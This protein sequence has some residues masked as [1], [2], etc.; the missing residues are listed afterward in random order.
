M[1]LSVSL[2]PSIDGITPDGVFSFTLYYNNKKNDFNK[3]V[4]YYGINAYIHTIHQMS[5][6]FFKNWYMIIYTNAASIKLLK[7]AFDQ[8]KYPKLLFAV[9]SWP[10]YEIN[11]SIE[12]TIMRTLRFHAISL[13]PES[14]I[15]VRDADT[16]FAYEIKD[17]NLNNYTIYSEIANWELD[18]L[19]NIRTNDEAFDKDIIIG[20]SPNYV[21]GWHSNMPSNKVF[22][23]KIEYKFMNGDKAIYIAEYVKNTNPA[24]ILN[25]QN[26]MF[27]RSK[28]G[29]YAGFVNF[30][31][32]RKVDY[33]KENIEKYI[34]DR[35]SI[36]T[37][38]NEQYIS[39][40]F[41]PQ[42][43]NSKLTAIQTH[44]A[45]IFNYTIGKDERAIIFGIIPYYLD[46]CYFYYIPYNAEKGSFYMRNIDNFYSN[47]INK[48]TETRKYNSSKKIKILA[49]RVE[50]ATS[51]KNKETGI[52]FHKHIYNI[53]SDLSV[54]YLAWL[55]NFNSKI[56]MYASNM[57]TK[58]ML[59]NS[60]NPVTANNIFIGGRRKRGTKKYKKKNA[61][62]KS[63]KNSH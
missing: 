31:K 14:D 1:P 30:L 23:P 38:N 55:E 33:W 42:L 12:N 54:K 28:Q 32:S 29:I 59:K 61:A 4:Y 25:N 36:V 26:A 6:E 41:V 5:N 7:E 10:E 53:F 57:A 8:I 60:T 3:S 24:Y 50:N 2:E 44:M 58:M 27:F 46:K 63:R 40:K 16:I 37:H 20:T 19:Q 47:V 17:T 15:A 62:R 21:V 45:E 11:G 39:N 43:D 22:N 51:Y 34:T 56:N 9:C 35:Y 49:S 48:K 52:S 18:F 13:F